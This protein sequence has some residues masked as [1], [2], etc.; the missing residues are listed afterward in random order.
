MRRTGARWCLQAFLIVLS[1]SW[2]QLPAQQALP[3]NLSYEGQKVSQVEIGGRPDINP[4]QFRRLVLQAEN[5]PYSQQKVDATVAALKKAGNFKDVTVEVLPQAD[6]LEVMFVL[7]PAMYFGVLEFGDAVKRFSY[8]R[9]LQVAGYPDQEPYTP[10]RVED[11]DDNLNDFFHQNGYFQATV[12]P[13]LQ[14]DSERGI[15][16]VL[17]HVNLKRHSDFGEIRVTGLSPAQNLQLARSLR[18]IKARLRGAYLKPGRSYSLRRIE[19]ARGYLQAQMANQHYLAARVSTSPPRYN[20]NKNRADLDFRVT[21]GP[22]ITINIVGAHVWGRTQKKLIPMYQENTVDPDLVH[23]GEQDLASYF[24]S[25]GFFDVKV[26]SRIVPE[27]GGTVITYQIAKGPRGKVTSVGFH[28]NQYFSDG[29]LSS[30]V[31]VKKRRWYNPWSHGAFSQQRVQK[32]V[33]NIESAYEAAGYSKVSVSPSVQRDGKTLSV[34]FAVSEGQRDIVD[35]LDIQGNKSI[36]DSE[37]APKGLNL[38]PGQPYSQ[39]LLDKDRDRILATYLDRGYLI[40]QFRSKVEPL[41]NDPHRVQVVYIIDEGPRVST[42]SLNT[43]GAVHTRPEIIATNANIKAGE[44]LSETAMLR[45]ESQLYTLGVFDWASVD[46]RRPVTEQSDADVLVKLHEARRNTI[47]YGFGFQ[48]INRGGNVPSG[49][50][51]LPGLPPVGLPSSFQTSEK[52]FWGPEGSIEYTRRNFR[53]RAE[54]VTLTGF[55][56]RLNQHASA[57]WLNPTFWN[58][59]WSSTLTVSAERSSENPIF[60]SRFGDAG[61]QFQKYLD[62]HKQKSIIVRYDFRRTNLTNVLIPELVLPED[63]N[64]RLSTLSGSFIRD[65]R[66]NPLDA[67]KGFYESFELDINPSALG[68]NTNFGKFL[69]QTA[70]YRSLGGESVVW[71]NSLRLGLEQAFAGAHIP[72]SET[73]FSGGGSTLRGFALNGAGP[74]RQVEVCNNGASGCNQFISVPVGGPQLVILNSEL[75]FPSSIISKLGGVVFYDGGN[76]YSSVGFHDFF[77]NFSNTV[78]VGAR[79]ATPVGPVRIDIGHLLN[80]PPGVKT[81]QIFIT[82][83]QAF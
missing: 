52:T 20:A 58:S 25:K 51:A 9:L 73:F 1:F 2:V 44:P 69:G 79:Y 41:K 71:A 36:P 12:E 30:R 46:P 66:D 82:L 26:T 23:E 49:T 8:T 15:V 83:G 72:I 55:G 77:S 60:T 21:Q 63:R 48:V 78:G 5:A 27:P 65:S 4:L 67:H 33:K 62:S 61:L 45:G 22:R 14:P 75:R 35:R 16:N 32:S 57:N 80:A 68:S 54:T 42:K 56:G 3:S 59:S 37:L 28:G 70:Y 81:T 24:Q 64:V 7:Q 34:A 50:V 10:A 19:A 6:G 39:Q 76:V 17:F 18:S 74:Q 11:A 38:E 13:E 40:A 53:G 29:D 31:A 47:A 43:L